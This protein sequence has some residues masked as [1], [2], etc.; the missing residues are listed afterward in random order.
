MELSETSVVLHHST[1][2]SLVLLDELGKYL[3]FISQCE[4][5]F[6]LFFF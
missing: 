1:L 3:F 6:P 2:H 4:G 5:M